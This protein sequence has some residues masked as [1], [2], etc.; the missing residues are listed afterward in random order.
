MDAQSSE[1]NGSALPKWSNHWLIILV[2]ALLLILLPMTALGSNF[3]CIWFPWWPLCGN[4]ESDCGERL[5]EVSDFGSNPGNLKMCTYVPENL[6]PSRPLVVALHGCKQQAEDYDNETGW[7]KFAERN[8]FALLLP[9]QQKANNMSKCFNWFELNDIE[10]DKGEALSIRQ[11]IKKMA[12]DT[13]ID[14]EKVYITGLSAGGGMATVMLAV[15]PDMFAGGAIIA[16]IPY[17]CATNVGEALNECGVSIVPGQLAPMKDLSPDAWGN[18]VR[19]ASSHNGPY[20]RIS[21]W[22]GTSDTTVN[23]ADQQ[24]LVD[25]WTNVLGVDQ[26][27]DIEDTINGHEHKLYKNDN[28]EP[29]IETILISGM[30]HGTPIDPGGGDDQCGEAASYILDVGTC[31][32]YY[33][34]KFWGLDFQ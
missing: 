26:T 8:Q 5:T 27:P 19:N 16:G 11:M 9:Q 2:S 18:L 20:P 34:I 33:I 15:Y 28:G 12:S 7:I 30:G 31:S 3:W 22:Q 25:Q 29:L 24:E 4:N 1:F 32:S 14:P 17:K 13:D 10:R 6:E 21:I 23:P